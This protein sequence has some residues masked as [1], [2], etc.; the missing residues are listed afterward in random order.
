M[1]SDEKKAL[2]TKIKAYEDAKDASNDDR[3]QGENEALKDKIVEM[4]G[5]IDKLDI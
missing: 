5:E 2:T 3:L 1:L 4:Q